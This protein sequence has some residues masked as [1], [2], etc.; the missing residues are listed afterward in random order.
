MG[1]SLGVRFRIREEGLFQGSYTYQRAREDVA[2]DLSPTTWD[3]PHNLSLFASLPVLG[4]WTANAA[5]RLHSGRA[6]TPVRS[7]VFVP[8]RGFGDHFLES[9]FFF[10]ER[11]SLRLDGYARLDLGLRHR[12]DFL[13]A[14]WTFFAQVLNTLGS[15][16]P[17]DV[18]FRD[19]LQARASG[20]AGG[21]RN[22]LPTVPSFGVEVKW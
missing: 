2:G 5:F 21:I 17:V 4:G 7:R 20:L 16:N 9:R 15:Q 12:F 22:G 18:D 19:L 8:T 3:V 11:N 14:G 10:G 13:G 6:V 1:A